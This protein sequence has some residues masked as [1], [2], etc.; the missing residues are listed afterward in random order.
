M[1]GWAWLNPSFTVCLWGNRALESLADACA[2]P[3]PQVQELMDAAPNAAA[4]SD[5]GRFAILDRL[6]G[7]YLDA[8]MEACR[9][10]APLL[11]HRGGFVVRE[12]RWLLVASAL[13]LPRA[14][15]YGRVALRI[16]A[17]AKQQRGA[18]DN[19]VTGPPLITELGRAVRLLGVNGPD[20]LPEWTFF[21]D[22]PFRFPRRT[23][24]T[25][26]PFGVHLFDHSWAEG[27]E[28][29]LS[30]RIARAALQSLSP[31]DVAVGKRRE[32]QLELRRLAMVEMATAAPGG[33]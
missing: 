26:P 15:A 20:V 19:F 33:S 29:R 7:I 12:S 18:I 24:S 23:R 10:I 31:R 21:P 3:I 17:K 1:H 11:G 6:G 5:V 9:P 16:M 28:L 4:L 22:N 2:E 30:R 8:D 32:V 27:T 14:G 25:L 13:G